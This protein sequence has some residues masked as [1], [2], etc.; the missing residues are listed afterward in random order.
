MKMFPSRALASSTSELNVASERIQITEDLRYTN[1]VLQPFLLIGLIV[2]VSHLGFKPETATAFL[3]VLAGLIS[4]TA[5]GFLFGI[6]KILQSDIE[7]PS[8]PGSPECR[9][10]YNNRS[11][12][13]LRKS[14]IG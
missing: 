8:T 5:I 3:W 7:N 2:V 6:P 10:S 14:P 12:Q 13:I 4:G 11:I 1:R 9:S